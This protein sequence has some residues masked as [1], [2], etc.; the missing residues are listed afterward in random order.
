[1]GCDFP[2]DPP[3]KIDNPVVP[4]VNVIDTASVLLPL[5][6]GAGWVYYAVPRFGPPVSYITYATPEE[7]NGGTFYRVV[8]YHTLMGPTRVVQGFPVL[9]RNQSQG[10]AFYSYYSAGDTTA[11][12]RP[13]RPQFIL[14]Y[15]AK[16]DT[17]WIDTGFNTEYL[18]RVAVKDTSVADYTGLLHRVYRY[19]VLEKGK[20]T[21]TLYIIPG[22]AI[23]KVEQKDMMFHTVAWFGF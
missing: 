6:Q 15:P 23:L 13:P 16:A 22:K 19:E 7:L 1:M 2:S 11:S 20:E 10:L 17:S 3:L 8:Y 4:P 18:V 9:L 12:S 5:R 21:T 14:P